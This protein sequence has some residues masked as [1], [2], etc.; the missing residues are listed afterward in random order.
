MS[1]WRA[2]CERIQWTIA[3][4]MLSFFLSAW[5]P[6]ALGLLLLGLGLWIHYGG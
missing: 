1:S 2:W 3:F 4:A 6:I 5:F